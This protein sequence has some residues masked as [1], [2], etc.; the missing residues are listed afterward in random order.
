MNY[1]NKTSATEMF[2]LLEDLKA[3]QDSFLNNH[4]LKQGFWSEYRSYWI[5]FYVTWEG[6][7]IQR[8]T[9]RC[10]SKE[11]QNHLGA[12]FRI[13]FFWNLPGEQMT[14]VDMP[15]GI[16]MPH[17]RF[18]ILLWFSDIDLQNFCSSQVL[19]CLKCWKVYWREQWISRGLRGKDAIV[20]SA[21]LSAKKLVA[22]S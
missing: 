18:L 8:W 1:W 15:T 21:P 13:S 22:M 11:G 14:S 3:I 12:Y 6:K 7:K 16:D 10:P 2:S 4:Y 9:G 17:C 19:W 20:F 5:K